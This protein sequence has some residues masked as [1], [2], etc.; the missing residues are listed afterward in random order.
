MTLHYSLVR[1]YESADLIGQNPQNGKRKDETL[2]QKRKSVDG[3]KP[4]SFKL[5]GSD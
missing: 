1:S 4:F 5:W 3:F 2:N